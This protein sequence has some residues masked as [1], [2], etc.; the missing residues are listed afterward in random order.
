M[1]LATRLARMDHPL[2]LALENLRSPAVLCFVL[3]WIAAVIRS[4]LEYPEAVSKGL[5]M[6]LLFAI[7][8]KGGGSLASTGFSVHNVASLFAAM[9]LSFLLP[10]I[11]FGLLHILSN[12][13]RAEHASIAA[14]YGSISIVTFVAAIQ[15]LDDH[16]IPH[17]SILPA[18]A[19]LMETPAI[20]SGLLL[21]GSRHLGG[22]LAKQQPARFSIAQLTRK[23][24]TH[25][26]V[27][28][29][30]GA[31]LVGLISAEH[32]RAV[33]QPFLKD[34]F[35]GVLCLFL[36]DMGLLAA[37]RLRNGQKLSPR[38]LV[39]AVLMQSIGACAALALAYVL[40]FSVGSATLFAVLG[41]SA[42]YIAVPAAMRIALPQVNPAPALTLAL[43]VT[44]PLNITI[45]IPL[46]HRMAQ[47]LWPS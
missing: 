35:K 43:A 34:F 13:G 39:F 15:Y 7:G 36:L 12:R 2:L 45:G 11:A 38:L 41:A 5:S 26:S 25:G 24:M 17:E 44:F 28:L 47:A 1:G 4:D 18:M 40:D 10:L 6:Y 22:A 46:F 19:A 42:S 37:R 16:K 29:L 30:L 32:H 9:A 31:F 23:V 8:F 21:A 20:V 14:H 3:G 27:V 33:L